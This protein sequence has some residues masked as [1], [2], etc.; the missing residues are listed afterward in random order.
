MDT[1][2]RNIWLTQA[3]IWEQRASEDVALTIAV[4]QAQGRK[5]EIVSPRKP[6]P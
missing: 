2:H 3:A 1:K 4:D 6:V 5:Q